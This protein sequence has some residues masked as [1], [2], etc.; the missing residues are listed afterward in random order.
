MDLP[1][2]HKFSHINPVYLHFYKITFIFSFRY[3][4]IPNL[5]NSHVRKVLRK[6]ELRVLIYLI[7]IFYKFWYDIGFKFPFFLFFVGTGFSGR[8]F[9]GKL[10]SLVSGTSK[11]TLRDVLMSLSFYFFRYQL[12]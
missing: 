7:L 12:L 10:V 6:C 5:T 2:R 1:M 9:Q 8:F 4:V 11:L 3:T